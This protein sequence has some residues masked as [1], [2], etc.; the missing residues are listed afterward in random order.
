LAIL[1]NGVRIVGLA[2]L[3]NYVDP[4][5]ITDSVLHR[6]GGI[7]LFVLSLSVLVSVVWLL[8]KLERRS[9]YDSHNGLR[10]QT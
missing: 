2:V 8:R 7:P 10:V 3:A 4:S 1:K 5:F 6:R 9:G